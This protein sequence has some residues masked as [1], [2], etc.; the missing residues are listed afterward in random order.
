MAA[1]ERKSLIPVKETTIVPYNN[2]A[3]YTTGTIIQ[4][5]F[6]AGDVNTWLVQDSFFQF[7]YKI[8]LASGASAA[9]I[10]STCMLFDWVEVIYQGKQV[11]I[12]NFNQQAKFID[13]VQEGGDYLDSEIYSFTTSKN[14]GYTRMKLQAGAN[15]LTSCI[16]RVGE[17]FNIFSQ[18]TEIPMSFLDNQIQLNFHLA[19]PATYLMNA[20]SANNLIHRFTPIASTDIVA[21]S[22]SIDRFEFHIK[23]KVESSLSS[24]SPDRT[25]KFDYSMP[26]IALRGI[27]A[28]DFPASSSVN[29]PF[30]IV[31]ENVDNMGIYFYKIGSPTLAYRP[32]LI[33]VNFKYGNNTSPFSP[34][35]VDNYTHPGVYK[36]IINDVFDIS[37]AIYNTTNYDF[38]RS[39]SYLPAG[40]AD[41]NNGKE[42]CHIVLATDF[43]TSAGI[44][45]SPSSV[46]NS[47]YIFQAN[48]S[49]KGI[50]Q[51]IACMWVKSKYIAYI[52][53]GKLE[54]VNI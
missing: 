32:E 12:Q 17:L 35:N 27:E 33:N 34:I 20:D 30:S 52:R 29:L 49:G 6:G 37:S 51:S 46:W 23:D 38:D 54:S 48:A 24:M 13:Y 45:G 26:Q 3:V 47:Q 42:D 50:P 9:Y 15:V 10:R 5:L 7:N 25:L 44:L 19:D 40:T 41:A 43:V 8:T 16:I 1:T 22:F 2:G 11:Y 36:A 4:I 18:V 53:D 21:G 39:Y 14:L 28:G 31:T